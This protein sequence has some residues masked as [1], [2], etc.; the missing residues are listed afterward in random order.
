MKLIYR[1]ALGLAVTLIPITAI[2]AMLFYFAMIREV[3]DETDDS[4][5]A[6]AQLIVRRCYEGR[7]LPMLNSGSNNIYTIEPATEQYIAQYDGAEFYDKSVYIPEHDETE[8]ARVMEMLFKD[9]DGRYLKLTVSTPTIDKQDI[10]RTILGWSITLFT[11]LLIVV[12]SISMIIIRRSLRPL[13][14]L[15]KWLDGYK[16]GDSAQSVPNDTYIKEF[17]RLNEAAQQ[18]VNR[19]EELLDR[20]TQFIG[21]ASHELQTPLA[22]IGNRVEYII[23][24]LAPNEPQLIELMKI[25]QSLRHSVRLNRTLLMLMRIESGQVAESSECD[26]NA[27]VAEIV[28]TMSEIYEERGLECVVNEESHLCL[29]INETLARTLIGNLIK[30]SFIYA[31]ERSHITI[32]LGEHSLRIEN[33]GGEPLDKERVFDRFYTH[34]SREG[35]TG[36]GLAIVRSIATHYGYKAEYDFTN[37]RHIFTLIFHE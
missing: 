2:W 8:P 35:S 33:E 1:I 26:I 24:H 13:Y 9:N 5:R 12:L 3:N 17:R 34:T 14:A 19:S 15:L 11:L 31:T 29:Y 6:Y 25:Q 37:N 18:A 32:T 27:I 7:P 23:D 22:V 4:L 30:N 10:R 20:Q 16:P 21:N 28:G 36:L